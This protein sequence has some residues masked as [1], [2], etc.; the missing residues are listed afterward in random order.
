M[1]EHYGSYG[2]PMSVVLALA[3]LGALAI[4]ILPK[5][6]QLQNETPLV[7]NPESASA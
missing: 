7:S 3:T 4:A 5:H 6:R 1:R 2:T